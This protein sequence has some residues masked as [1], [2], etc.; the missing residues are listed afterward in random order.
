MWTRREATG[1]EVEAFLDPARAA[2]HDPMT[3]KGMQAAVRLVVDAIAAGERI[4]IFGDYDADGVTATAVLQRGLTALGAE[5]ITH[6]PHRLSDGYG[7]S[8]D[9]LR[10]LDRQGARLVISCDCGTN[11]VDVVA[12]RPAGQRLIVTDHHLP[13][14]EIARPDALLNPHQ[15]GC[16]YP[17]KELSGAG[18]AFKLV[19]AV[20]GQPGMTGRLGEGGL[21][22]LLQ[23]VAVGAIAD[24]VPLQ[25]ENRTL[26][27]LGLRA[28]NSDPLPGIAAL[29]RTGSIRMP[30]AA[31]TV[32]FQVAPRINA[33]GRMDDARLALDLL[34]ARTPEEAQPLAEQ[35]EAHNLA[36]RAAT[37][38]AVAE[39]EELLAADDPDNAAIVLA[40]GRWPLGLVGLI[41]GRLAEAH[42]RPAFILNRGQEECRGSAR[43]VDGFHVV[44][45][46]DACARYLSRY[47]GHVA[48]AGFACATADYEVFRETLLRHAAAV[49][50]EGGWE[51]LMDVDV[52]AGLEL[53]TVSALREL[54]VL[55]PHGEGNPQVRFCCR[56]V[57][58][59]AAS[60]FG[61]ERT[62]LRLWL[63]QDQKVLEAIAWG[64]AELLEYFRPGQRLD[65]LC[66]AEI[67]RWDGD[68]TV[69]LQLEDVRRAA[70][71]VAREVQTA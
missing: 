27:W 49:R 48:A 52:E 19:H 7:L 28:V 64:R 33:A 29:I 22:Q 66:S 50:P 23:L 5:V 12:G 21:E 26:C 16:E 65:I 9:G 18:V 25:E 37:E 54:E 24:V 67:N 63:A 68:P 41:A 4:A 31:T 13:A 3:M 62:H 38:R 70:A 11:S 71:A 56:G 51:R 53:M 14:A 10:E 46:L 15:P 55:E 8:E 58:V 32:A 2:L 17:F 60:A 47:G 30:L 59:K 36:R 20:A 44:E 39:A 69:R 42:H 35:V 6:I 61:A 45:A 43:H 40:D 57:E 34:L 1:G